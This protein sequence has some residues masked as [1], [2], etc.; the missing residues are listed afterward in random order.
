MSRS[1]VEEA[2]A[3]VARVDFLPEARRAEAALDR[4][5]DLGFG[6]T[7]SQPST[8]RAMLELLEIRPQDAILDVGSGSGWTTALLAWLAGPGGRVLGLELE[9]ALVAFGRANLA[10]AEV[11]NGVIRQA[12]PGTLGAPDV[13]P[14]DRILVSAMASSLPERLVAQLG[15]AGVLVVP[16]DGVLHRVARVGP[17]PMSRRIT[18]H[19]RH[20]FVPLR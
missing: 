13:A 7:N 20:R 14:F 11:S 4:P 16:V 10:R 1:R 15:P 9:P 8:V 5:I 6:Q 3:R 2:L 19:G 12:E 17:E 18:T